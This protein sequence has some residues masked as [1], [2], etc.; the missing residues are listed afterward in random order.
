MNNALEVHVPKRI[1][2]TKPNSTIWITIFGC[3]WIILWFIATWWI[4][5]FLNLFLTGGLIV[6]MFYLE[7]L[8]WNGKNDKTE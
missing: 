3:I 6:L 8:D 5:Y 4:D 7:Y 2:M 1:A